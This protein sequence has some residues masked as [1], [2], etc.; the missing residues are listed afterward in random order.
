MFAAA[1]FRL[2][3][4]DFP[5]ACDVAKAF[6]P[7]VCLPFTA[8]K[9]LGGDSAESSGVGALNG[10]G[11]SVV[12]EDK[13]EVDAI[14]VEG[15]AAA[16]DIDFLDFFGGGLRSSTRRTEFLCA[17]TENGSEADRLWAAAVA[18][19]VV[20]STLELVGGS[21]AGAGWRELA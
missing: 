10:E 18:A 2:A 17:M 1:A 15:E 19:E 6:A 4:V 12:V 8:E 9:S 13:I 5:F 21:A 14:V 20:E 16:A 11:E 3:T 7:F